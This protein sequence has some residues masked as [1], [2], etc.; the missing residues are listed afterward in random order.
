MILIRF[1]FF[2]SPTAQTAM[3][4]R[5]KPSLLAPP[6]EPWSMNRSPQ[7]GGLAFNSLVL[8][9]IEP[10]RRGGKQFLLDEF[11][12]EGATFGQLYR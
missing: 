8:D 7:A 5:N 9:G 3:G 1:Y 11:Y 12:K 4:R 10:N 6:D 2:F